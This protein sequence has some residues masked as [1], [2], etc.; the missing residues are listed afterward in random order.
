MYYCA[1]VGVP[2]RLASQLTNSARSPAREGISASMALRICARAPSPSVSV[3]STSEM[4][5][6]AAARTCASSSSSLFAASLTLS[7]ARKS[8]LPSTMAVS[9]H[10]CSP[11]DR[12][13]PSRCE[14]RART[15]ASVR[16]RW[17]EPSLSSL[18]CG[19]SRACANS[20]LSEGASCIMAAEAGIGRSAMSEPAPTRASDSLGSNAGRLPAANR[21]ACSWM[22]PSAKDLSWSM[23]IMLLP[24]T[25]P[26]P[27]GRGMRSRRPRWW[28]NPE[29]FQHAAV[30][31]DAALNERR[32]ALQL[33]W[34]TV[35]KIGKGE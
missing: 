33:L 2:G 14:Q 20:N 8:S 1:R 23:C 7:S 25:S 4:A 19:R 9:T 13:C 27:S 18:P 22:C 12:G 10:I 35:A 15:N 3:S 34:R 26:P 16:A 6:A 29:T 32:D 24:A 28:R 31:L 21:C 17:S 30:Y 5:A 11:S